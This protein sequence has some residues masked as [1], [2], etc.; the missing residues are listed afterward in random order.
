MT[1]V[2]PGGL[3]TFIS[4]PYGGKASDKVIFHESNL[5]QL[6]DKTSIMAD[7]GFHI[8]KEC[9]ENGIQL[10]RP[11]F[12][13]GKRQLAKEEAIYNINIAAARVHIERT[14]Q[15]M[16]SFKILTSKLSPNNICH[17]QEI[18]VIIAAIVNLSSPILANDKFL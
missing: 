6:V 3:I 9:E 15:R 16:K 13:K 10:Y 1:G 14:Y 17:F 5:I 8:E 2:S 7:K 12:L 4:Q 11:P 18:F